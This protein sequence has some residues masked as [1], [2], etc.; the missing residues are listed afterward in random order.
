LAIILVVGITLSQEKISITKTSSEYR[1]VAEIIHEDCNIQPVELPKLN[2]V[3]KN[4]I[5]RNLIDN[6]YLM[7][8]QSDSIISTSSLKTVLKPQEHACFEVDP[9]NG[10]VTSIEYSYELSP[11]AIQAIAQSPIWIRDQLALKFR[12]LRNHSLQT[13]KQYAGII[14]NS[15]QKYKDEVAFVI[16]NTSYQTLTDSRF[17]QDKQAIVRNAEMIYRYA[18]SLN[19]VKLVEFGNFAQ[20]MYGT[21]TK[22]RIYDPAQKD[23]IWTEIP[24][25]IYYWYIVHPKMDQEGVYVKDNGNDASG[26]R[27]YDYAWRQFIWSNPDPNHDYSNVNITTSKGSVTSIPRFGDIIKQATIL[28]DRNKTY[29]PFNRPFAGTVSALD[30]IGNWCSRALPVD[31]T[32]PRA[33]QPNQILMKHNGMCNEDA[34]LVASACRTALIPIIYLGTWCEDHVFGSVWDNN[35]H[36]FEFFRGGLSESGNAFYGITNMLDRGSY[37]WK[38]SMVQGFRPDGYAINFT[39]NYANTS[40]LALRVIDKL[41]NPIPGASLTLF[42]SPNAYNANYMECGTSYTDDDGNANVV[43]GEGKKYLARVYHPQFGWAPL[44]STQAYVVTSINT[45]AGYTYKANLVYNNIEIKDLEVNKLGAQDPEKHFVNL[46]FSTKDIFSAQNKRDSQRSRFYFWNI[47][48]EGDIS[49][50]ICDSSNFEKFKSQQPFNAYTYETNIVTGN[51]NPTIKSNEKT[52]I[53]LSNHGPSDYYQSIDAECTLIMGTTTPVEF[54]SIDNI[55]VFPNPANSYLH[56]DGY[57]GQ[58]EIFNLMANRVL[59]ANTMSNDRIDIS[60]LPEGIYFVRFMN[61]I[62][63]FIISR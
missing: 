52:Y 14:L 48:N 31:V 21:T 27:T 26:Q 44:D 51:I 57:N 55:S 42:A 54:N 40:T 61:Q 63:S 58:V 36:H 50:I 25:D 29:L 28:W 5:H 20:G 6:R 39:E 13:E 34:F 8:E 15:E 9:I 45:Q 11:E 23:T 2:I 32:L 47:D 43:V 30:I 3:P 46:K 37:G 4:I 1:G 62:K 10:K 41:G 24:S 35:W 56:I 7:I 19:Y 59:E 60:S 18:D 38:N 16:A 49:V 22:Y 17:A 12:E 33:F 53:I